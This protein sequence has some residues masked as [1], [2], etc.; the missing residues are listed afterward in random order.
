MLFLTYNR[1]AMEI[2]RS[3]IPANKVYEKYSSGVILTIFFAL[4]T[5]G[6][7]VA[8]TFLPMV[9]YVPNGDEPVKMTGLNLV[10]YALRYFVKDG[11]NQT[12]DRFAA[13]VN[14]YNG[15][16]PILRLVSQYQATAEILVFGFL[17]ICLVFAIVIV[18]YTL[19]LLLKGYLKNTFMISAMA[20]SVAS[21]FA[22]F[23]GMLFLY[24]FLCRKMFYETNVF[25]YIKFYLTPFF[26]AAGLIICATLLSITYKY[27]FRRRVYIGNYKVPRYGDD[28][29][30]KN[31]PVYNY[32]DNFPN[33]TTKIDDHSFENNE[34]IEEAYIPDGILILGVRAFANCPKLNKVVIPVSVKEIGEGCFFNSTNLTR[35]VYQGSQE[36]WKQ[37]RLG[38]NW[39]AGTSAPLLETSDG[40]MVLR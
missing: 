29:A 37:V 14:N 23:L 5:I 28:S 39:A 27:R 4:A 32:F 21:F 17:A 8:F 2:D 40:K 1:L 30:I 10:C 3:K 18:F 33:G 9:I 7:L 34:G 16:V 19:A 35:V 36:Q 15:Q 26:L 38:S 24:F 20:N 22:F 11:Y 31:S 12:F 6:I 25:D 13:N